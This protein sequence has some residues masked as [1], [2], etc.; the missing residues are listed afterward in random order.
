MQQR[1]LAF[2]GIAVLGT[3]VLTVLSMT[4]TAVVESYSV[5]DVSYNYTVTDPDGK[6]L[7]GEQKERVGFG[8]Y[9]QDANITATD[10]GALQL[11]V[12]V[13]ADTNVTIISSP[14]SYP[15]G[16]LNAVG[17]DSHF[18]LYPQ[19]YT[20]PRSTSTSYRGPATGCPGWT[21][22]TSIHHEH[23]HNTTLTT[24]YTL[25]QTEIS[26][27]RQYTITSY[28]NY[29]LPERDPSY[30]LKFNVTFDTV[31]D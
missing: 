30:H 28:V 25:N 1:R 21:N 15:F 3:F 23:T 29:T 6:T 31:P 9:L 16:L 20:G 19:D 11:S 18:C 17:N 4:S 14:M 5:Q 26:T 22:M 13:N 2:I 7:D 12:R 27:P 24:E 10:P 8:A